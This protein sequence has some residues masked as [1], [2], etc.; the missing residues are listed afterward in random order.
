MRPNKNYKER[1]KMFDLGIG[2]VDRTDISDGLIVKSL[3]MDSKAINEGVRIGDIITHIN[4]KPLKHDAE[5]LFDK[6]Y[7]DKQKEGSFTFKRNDSTYK[8]KLRA[9]EKLK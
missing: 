9:E 1:M 4:G 5:K 2:V 7:D 6:V 8:L 3:S